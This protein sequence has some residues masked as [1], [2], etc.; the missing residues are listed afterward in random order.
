[1]LL[2]EKDEAVKLEFAEGGGEMMLM[3]PEMGVY[4]MVVG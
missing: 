3:V 4:S 2:A 1:V